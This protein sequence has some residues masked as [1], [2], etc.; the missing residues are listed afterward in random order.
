MPRIKHVVRKQVPSIWTKEEAERLL[1]AVDKGNPCG[2][3]DYAMLLLIV[4]LG[5]RISDVR[6]LQLSNLKW[7]LGSVEFN[8]IKTGHALSLPLLEDVGWA[9]ID[10]LKHGRPISDSQN[11][12][13]KHIAPFTAFSSNNNLHYLINKYLIRAKIEVP[14][15]K[16]HGMHSLRHTLASELLQQHV[17]LPIIA[18]ILGHRDIN[19]TANYLRVDVSLLKQ[20]AL[21]VEVQHE[22]Y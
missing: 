3:R 14:A 20:C 10:Y 6:S 18:E 16:S 2:K 19:T 8:Q 17:S 13:I 5:L 4:R 15:E 9:I 21:N 1:A 7:D 22:E 11:V 12:F